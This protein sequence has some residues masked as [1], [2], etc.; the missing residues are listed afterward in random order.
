MPFNSAHSG[1]EID[2][3]V[4][5]LGQIQDARD[6][7]GQDLA[8]VKIL[9]S[10]VGANASQVQAQAESVAVKSEQVVN[11]ALAV[12]S[13][14][15]EVLAASTA[16]ED[17]KDAAAASAGSAATSRSSAKASA[18]A[19][20]QSE[21]AAGLSEQVTAENAAQVESLTEQVR[22]DSASARNDAESAEASA[23]A[24]S[25]LIEGRGNKRYDTYAE[26][27][28]DPQ[29]RGAIIGIVDAD[30]DASLNGW[31][32]WSIDSA[33]WVIFD[34]QP[35]FRNEVNQILELI[36]PYENAQVVA[37]FSDD[38][39]FEAMQIDDQGTLRTFSIELGDSGLSNR[40]MGIRHLSLPGLPAEL[41]MADSEGFYYL[42][43]SEPKE[44]KFV[45]TG[46]VLGQ[47]KMSLANELEDVN[48]RLVGD[49]I[50]W[51]V[52]VTGGSPQ[53]PRSHTLA[54]TRNNMISSSWAN[55]LHKYMGARYSS[56]AFTNPAPGVA[57]YETTHRVDI[58]VSEK[59]LAIITATS[60]K[61][62]KNV[63]VDPSA[64][65]G[66]RCVMVAGY[67]LKFDVVG[68]GFTVIYT[69]MVDSGSFQVIVDGAIS[70]TVNTSGSVSAYGK[71][72][73]ITLPFGKHL[74]EL[75]CIGSVSFEGIRRVR[76]IR[77]ANDGLIGTNTQEWLPSGTIL[78]VSVAE[79]DTHVF[80]QLGTNDRGMNS[81]PN[82]P[83][84]TKRNLLSIANYISNTRG[85][86]LVMMAANFADSDYP[87]SSTAKYSQADVAR[88]VGQVAFELGCGYIDNYHSTLKQ[89]LAGEAFL[90]DGLHP[91]DVGHMQIFKN[92]VNTIEQA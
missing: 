82:D 68:S 13:A 57:L 21:I 44:E 1:P 87:S 48:I 74:V 10:E 72:V 22:N 14:H 23:Q 15:A 67:S 47:L 11:S 38:D 9:A 41:G 83:A 76:K 59:I 52:V 2:A 78:P 63:V 8:E 54:D 3:A 51:G 7:T 90:A 25:R 20:G 31:Y 43:D 69:E 85:K 17:S 53:D 36:S 62:G 30:I 73:D 4:Q 32:S 58:G 56:G 65:L 19:A 70:R 16:A 79:D 34:N 42:F 50:T 86:A 35:A 45:E 29:T 91:N 64:A 71:T 6:S 39:G 92:I 33:E 77:V 46:S 55:L 40:F 61:A 28:A 49:S 18:Q 27:V 81:A 12:E 66:N 24:A 75:R 80:V 37:S 88:M 60:E 5:M 26:M 84:R 89:K